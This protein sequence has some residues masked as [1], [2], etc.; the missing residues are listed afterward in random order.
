MSTTV[1]KW[2]TINDD[3]HVK[4]FTRKLNARHDQA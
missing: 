4:L 1:E 2:K 3:F